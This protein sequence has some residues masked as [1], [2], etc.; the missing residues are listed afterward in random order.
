M[1]ADPATE[2][3]AMRGEITA[4]KE[5]LAKAS[6]RFNELQA[7]QL[8]TNEFLTDTN[9]TRLNEVMWKSYNEA[10]PEM[11]NA[12][13]SLDEKSHG[14]FFRMQNKI[15]EV[16]KDMKDDQDWIMQ[17]RGNGNDRKGVTKHRRVKQARL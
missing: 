13:Q 7:A 1:V 4:M 16:I 14:N 17:S 5:D 2:M 12:V 3:A 8:V 9:L 15:S 10:F 11:H 6:V